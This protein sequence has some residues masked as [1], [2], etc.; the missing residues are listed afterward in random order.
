M[1]SQHSEAKTNDFKDSVIISAWTEIIK[2]LM[3]IINKGTISGKMQNYWV[4]EC[5][6]VP[7]KNRNH[8]MMLNIVPSNDW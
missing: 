8:K 7:S 5:F 4:W 6:Q 2:I 1:K 3:P